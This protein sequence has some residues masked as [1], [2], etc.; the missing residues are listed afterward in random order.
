MSAELRRRRPA[1]SGPD[2]TDLSRSIPVAFPTFGNFYKA[3]LRH[4]D[5]TGV[6]MQGAMLAGSDLRGAVLADADLSGANLWKVNLEDAGLIRADLEGVQ[7][8]D[9]TGR[10]PGCSPQ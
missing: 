6:T 5:L 8:C 7:G 1:R 10:L 3:D 2:G 4:A 9:L